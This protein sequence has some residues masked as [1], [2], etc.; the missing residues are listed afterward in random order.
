MKGKEDLESTHLEVPRTRSK[1]GGRKPLTEKY[2]DIGAELDNLI[3]PST[4]ACIIHK[5]M[6][7]QYNVL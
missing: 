3:E 5:K 4:L 6:T 2:P 7:N 1:G